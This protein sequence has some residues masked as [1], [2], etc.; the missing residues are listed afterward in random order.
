MNKQ[1]TLW[2]GRTT[3]TRGYEFVAERKVTEE[4]AQEWLKV[5]RADE[6]S[7]IFIVSTTKPKTK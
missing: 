1:M 4:T 6:P 3:V 5:F 2:A 7:V